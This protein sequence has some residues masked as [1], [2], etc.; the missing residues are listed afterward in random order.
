MKWQ[1]VICKPNSDTVELTRQAWF[2]FLHRSPTDQESRIIRSRSRRGVCSWLPFSCHWR[3]MRKRNGP[4]VEP[5]GTPA[6]NFSM[7]WEQ[8]VHR[9]ALSP[10]RQVWP[11][12]CSWPQN[13]LTPLPSVSSGV[14][15]CHD[16]RYWR[17]FASPTVPLLC[18][19]PCPFAI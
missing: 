7:G 14:G 9:Y 6:E 10:S 3:N 5:C 17:R 13:C 12:P 2:Y 16:S 18:G 11:K 19:T 15:L 8:A 1:F 4:N